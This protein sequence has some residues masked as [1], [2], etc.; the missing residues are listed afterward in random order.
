MS[1]FNGIT[2]ACHS[3]TDFCSK[4]YTAVMTACAS[5]CYNKAM[6]ALFNVLGEQKFQKICYL[7]YKSQCNIVLE[8]IVCNILV[9]TCMVSEFRY[10][11]RVGKKTH[12]KYQVGLNRNSIFKAE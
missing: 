6:L 7:V 10:I 8:Y 1:V 9:K 4:C 2:H 12:V 3:F 5:E 11:E